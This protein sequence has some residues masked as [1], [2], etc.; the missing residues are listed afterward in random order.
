MAV[1]HYNL[2]AKCKSVTVKY[3]DIQTNFKIRKC[4]Y[5]GYIKKL[6]FENI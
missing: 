1:Y 4:P 3:V 2:S 5:I 6:R